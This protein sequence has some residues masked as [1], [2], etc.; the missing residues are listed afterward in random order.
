MRQQIAGSL[1]AA[2][3]AVVI[4][5]YDKHFPRVVDAFRKRSNNHC[6]GFPTIGAI[7]EFGF[8]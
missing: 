4:V 5:G 3:T 8:D 1:V 2:F 7:W 6:Q